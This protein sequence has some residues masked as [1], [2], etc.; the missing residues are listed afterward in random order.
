LADSLGVK[1][2]LTEAY[3]PSNIGDGELVRAS[4]ALIGQQFPNSSPAVIALDHGAFKAA[5]PM[6]TFHPRPF[7]RRFLKRRGKIYALTSWGTSI[8]ALTAISFFPGVSARRW[9]ARLCV[10]LLHPGHEGWRA[11]ASA[12]V[13]I[14][15]GGGYL[16]DKYTPESYLT[17][18]TYWWLGR[19]GTQV[20]TMPISISSAS[21]LLRRAL[22]WV[23]PSL[24]WTARESTTFQLLSNLGI[25][26]RAAPDL[27]FVNAVRP[28]SAEGAPN[29]RPLLIVAPVGE[30]YVPL[31]LLRGLYTDLASRIAE[32]W[33]A[34]TDVG[35]VAMHQET[36]GLADGR[37]RAAVDIF[38]NCAE[39]AGL[40]TRFIRTPDYGALL[41]ALDR[42]D[43][44]VACR[45][46]AAIGGICA[47]TPTLAI[48]YE[49]KHV[50]VF[51]DLH[52]SDF[53]L[54]LGDSQATLSAGLDRLMVADRQAFV[55]AGLK[56]AGRLAEWQTSFLSRGAV[57]DACGS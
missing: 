21:G 37:D 36:P 15:V 8:F 33:P 32:I 31:P 39:A 41:V 48:A 22:G 23:G 1:V 6:T 13:V 2:V 49:P 17:L 9:I 54:G 26:V 35:I 47:G 50:G 38:S 42:A 30:D 40:K 24:C 51:A 18:W 45:L 25:H 57:G 44:L 12:N 20:M 29:G 16:G 7:D 52:L 14:P 10:Q 46:H 5:F 28:R 27:A 34:D 55:A 3:S 19:Q 43:W 11:L 4:L 56:A 53:V